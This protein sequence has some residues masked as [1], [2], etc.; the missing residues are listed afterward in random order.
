[1]NS[2]ITATLVEIVAKHGLEG[3]CAKEMGALIVQIA[4]TLPPSA[5][6]HRPLLISHVKA[7]K[8]VTNDQCTAAIKFLIAATNGDVDVNVFDRACGVGVHVKDADIASAVSEVFASNKEAICEERYHFNFMKLMQPIKQK[9]DMAWA[10]IGKVKA[11]MEIQKTNLLGPKTAEDEK[12]RGKARKIK[13][14]KVCHPGM[15]RLQALSSFHFA[16]AANC[17][18]QQIAL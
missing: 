17:A 18:W 12:P 8:I 14:P 4:S 9:G 2:K 15:S 5:V 16:Q 7:G 10:D 6:A 11:E 3:G 13:A 1:L